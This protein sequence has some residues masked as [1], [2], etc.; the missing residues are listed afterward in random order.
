MPLQ[1]YL[2]ATKPNM[3][4][5]LGQALVWYTTLALLKSGR[6]EEAGTQLMPLTEQP[7]LIRQMPVRLQ[8]MLLK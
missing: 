6:L 2:N 4:H 3:D 5:Q 8:K 1:K 7:G